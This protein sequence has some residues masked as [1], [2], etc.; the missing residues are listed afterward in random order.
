VS[1]PITETCIPI[2]QQS[3]ILSIDF[4]SIVQ[5]IYRNKSPWELVKM[6]H[7]RP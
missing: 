3:F 2:F 7:F 1:N 4:N 6:A 5:M